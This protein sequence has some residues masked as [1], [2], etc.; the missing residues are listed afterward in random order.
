MCQNVGIQ[1]KYQGNKNVLNYLLG[2]LRDQHPFYFRC[3]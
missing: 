2:G 3:I 1:S